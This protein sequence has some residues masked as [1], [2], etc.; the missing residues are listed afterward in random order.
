MKLK[1]NEYK[2][3]VEGEDIRK[4]LDKTLKLRKEKK[5]E[6]VAYEDLGTEA[7]R[8]LEEGHHFLPHDRSFLEDSPHPQRRDERRTVLHRASRPPP[9]G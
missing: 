7:I 9:T 6:I 3:P 5:A 2:P 8:R 4:W 1:L